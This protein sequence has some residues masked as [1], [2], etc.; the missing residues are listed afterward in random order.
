MHQLVPTKTIP[1]VYNA[2]N[3]LDEL[4][5]QVYNYDIQPHLETIFLN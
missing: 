5:T 2:P 1:G 3:L 4:K